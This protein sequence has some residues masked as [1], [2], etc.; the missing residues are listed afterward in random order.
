MSFNSVTFRGLFY[1][2]SIMYQFVLAKF[3]NTRYGLVSL[4]DNA[5][6]RV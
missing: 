2:C 1:D 4:H 5:V 6:I 3:K